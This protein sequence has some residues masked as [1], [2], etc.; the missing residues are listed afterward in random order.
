MP[1]IGNQP[2]KFGGSMRGSM[3]GYGS[4]GIGQMMKSMEGGALMSR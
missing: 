4:M 1:K 3:F 2:I